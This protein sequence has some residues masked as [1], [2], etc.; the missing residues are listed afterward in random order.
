MVRHIILPISL[1]VG[2]I[3][4]AGMFSLPYL[5]H[6]TGLIL[7]LIVLAILTLVVTFIHL[8]YAD[9]ITQTG[10]DHN[11]ISYTKKYL[12]TNASRMAFFMT[13]VE[14]IIVLI[15][16]LIL[17]SKFI[18]SFLQSYWSFY[19]AD[20]WISAIVILFWLAGSAAIFWNLKEM[21]LVQF[22]ITASM[23]II[24]SFI[25]G[26]GIFNGGTEKL[27]FEIYLP[28]G[29]LNFNN[30]F[31]LI[32]PILFALSGRVVIVEVVKYFSPKKPLRDIKISIILGTVIPAIVY[33]F[34]VLS[35][36][37]LSESVSVDAISGLIGN[38]PPFL[39][40]SFSILG[41][42][43]IWTSYIAV[44]FDI[45]NILQIDL[46]LSVLKSGM[47]VV[48]LP[49]LFYFAGLNDFIFLI[50]LVGGL[51][52]ALEGIFIVKM[53]QKLNKTAGGIFLYIVIFILCITLIYEIWKLLTGFY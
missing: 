3:I 43:A 12:G 34:F 19:P 26:F 52:L 35:V 46:N 30:I 49:I 20:F 41:L 18:N 24:I 8:L 17:A 50:S 48:F 40:A 36:L 14:M 23:V 25:L 7:G 2:A 32:G 4:G 11:F 37:A 22:L 27:F 31:I 1:M 47:I 6:Q 51:F 29:G 13:I 44:G 15:I 16:Y 21:S 9:I 53:W 28:T 42:L 10:G 5:F 33:G 45:K 38:L 39:I